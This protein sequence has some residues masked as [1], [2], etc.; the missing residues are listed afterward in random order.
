MSSNEKSNSGNDS[1]VTEYH[2]IAG[3]VGNLVKNVDA[4]AELLPLLMTIMQA[5]RMVAEKKYEAYLTEHG[6]LMEEKKGIKQFRVG[7]EHRMQLTR[8]RR[9]NESAR[10]GSRIVPRT[11]VVSLV[12]HYDNFLGKL[13]KHLFILR[14]ELLSAVDRQLTFT[15]LAEFPSIEA[16]RE[17]VLELEIE[18]VMR[19]SHPDQFLWMEKRFQ[20]PLRKDLPI[21][22]QFVE[23]TERRNLF[24][25]TGGLVSSQYLTVCAAHGVQ[26]EADVAVGDMLDVSPTYFKNA[27]SCLIEISTKLAQVLWR[28]IDPT[29]IAIADRSLIEVTYELLEIENYELAKTLLD[30]GVNTLKRHSSDEDRRVLI[31][32]L[33]QS[34]KWLG[35][36]ET[37]NE[38]L[39]KED[40]SSCSDKFKLGI[41]VLQDNFDEAVSIMKRIG[42][43]GEVSD[44]DYKTWP[45]FK[46]F[47]KS[48][49]LESTFE[50]IFGKPFSTFE[51][52]E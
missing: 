41:A 47:R 33:A 17:Y 29:S 50:E 35:E 11:L 21:W 37:C 8:L 36:P 44:G 25:H 27:C 2:P 9:S 45:L 23:L 20:L 1:S 5:A 24:V 14:P 43:E 42:P 49:Q 22:P 16:A 30:F 48:E 40:W 32:N 12:S 34:H 6:E 52:V 26:Y 39:D 18:S 3:E 4:I 19:K 46:E 10:R 13:M 38:I 51:S 31:I 15:E 7:F 28:K